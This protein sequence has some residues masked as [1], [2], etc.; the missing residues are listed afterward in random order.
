MESYLVDHAITITTENFEVKF[1]ISLVS[2]SK[3]LNVT[4][5][6]HTNPWASIA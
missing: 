1:N 4:E 5:I 2:I 3:Y 6:T